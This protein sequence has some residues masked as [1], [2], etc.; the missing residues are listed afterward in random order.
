MAY[1]T[2]KSGITH[3]PKIIVRI[4]RWPGRDRRGFWMVVPMDGIK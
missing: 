2:A 4:S 3:M 1:S